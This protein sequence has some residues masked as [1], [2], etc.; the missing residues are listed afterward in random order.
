MTLSSS[1]AV[2]STYACSRLTWYSRPTRVTLA[3]PWAALCA[4]WWRART[5]LQWPCG[6]ARDCCG[7][8]CALALRRRNFAHACLLPG[9]PYNPGTQEG[10]RCTQPPPPPL[11]AC[12]GLAPAWW[13]RP[14]RRCPRAVRGRR[15]SR[16]R[17]P[18]WAAGPWLWLR[19]SLSRPLCRD[20]PPQRPPA[21]QGYPTAAP[22]RSAGIPHCSARP[23]DT[24]AR[25]WSRDELSQSQHVNRH[26]NRQTCQSKT[27]GVIGAGMCKSRRAAPAAL[28]HIVRTLRGA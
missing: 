1:C 8:G 5:V 21:L 28:Y 17:G 3:L 19:P 26:R 10:G 23:P 2:S 12:L 6:A 22:A 13:A 27:Y 11:Q 18:L 25:G 15:G 16:R 4:A 14:A 9:W 7:C 20:T 24:P